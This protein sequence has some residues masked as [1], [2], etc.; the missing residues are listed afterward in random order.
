MTIPP[1]SGGPQVSGTPS[2]Q[3]KREATTGTPTR[4]RRQ[5]RWL[6]SNRP[7][8]AAT[9]RHS[10]G[11]YPDPGGH[12]RQRGG[13]VSGALRNAEHG[14]GGAVHRGEEDRQYRVEQL[15]GGVLQ[16]RYPAQ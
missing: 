15:A 4:L 16:E 10:K 12:L 3:I 9:Q 2:R 1:A 7:L 14:D 5:L 6:S 13:T 8:G 11:R